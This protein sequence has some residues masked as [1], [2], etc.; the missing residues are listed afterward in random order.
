VRRAPKSVMN[1]TGIGVYCRALILALVVAT[2]SAFIVSIRRR[3]LTPDGN[4]L[5]VHT[6]QK[7]GDSDEK[8]VKSPADP[9]N[10][11]SV[12]K[13]VAIMEKAS[14]EDVESVN[15]WISSNI[16]LSPNA[17]PASLN[18]FRDSLLQM[19][20]LQNH[21]NLDDGNTSLSRACVIEFYLDMAWRTARDNRKEAPDVL[22]QYRSLNQEILATIDQKIV[23]LFPPE[24]SKEI[25]MKIQALVTPLA[26][27]TDRDMECLNGET[28]FPAF[29]D[30]LA[31]EDIRAISD[32]VISSGIIPRYGEIIRPMQ[33]VEESFSDQM[34]AFLSNYEST[35]IFAVASRQIILKLDNSE[36]WKG[37]AYTLRKNRMPW[38]IIFT[39]EKA[40]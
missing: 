19:F 10:F 16:Q 13:S 24:Q 35:Y 4:F 6:A 40:H 23:A 17:T 7:I 18:A 33:T 31:S 38:P 9:S 3:I 14:S 29:K 15:S 20:S 37:Y 2:A 34:N 12:W 25:G 36:D 21:A 30:P 1:A 28:L 32:E 27:N 11:N 22:S 8:S 26:H 39:L 5:A